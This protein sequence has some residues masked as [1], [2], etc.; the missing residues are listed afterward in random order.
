MAPHKQ[1]GA[2]KLALR[3]IRKGFTK[4]PTATPTL[5][6]TGKPSL[7]PTSSPSLSPSSSPTQAPTALATM[8]THK[9]GTIPPTPY[10]TRVPTPIQQL[11]AGG[12]SSQYLAV[13]NN[14]AVFLPTEGLGTRIIHH[15]HEGPTE[16]P[17]ATPTSQPTSCPT[18]S[19]T[20][21]PTSHPTPVQTLKPYLLGNNP[22]PNKADAFKAEA[23]AHFQI[24]LGA[25][26]GKA[27]DVL[28]SNKE[29]LLGFRYCLFARHACCRVTLTK[30]FCAPQFHARGSKR[31][32]GRDRE[33]RQ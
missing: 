17:T 4:D 3:L 7:L 14:P 1:G 10:P 26:H 21:T 30:F 8:P 5:M 18:Y 16:A 11:S 24:E 13:L 2:Y 19:P 22:P 31:G 29:P 12:I 15:F 20:S 6:P 28:V 9:Q 33:G 27:V 32:G 23:A 25:V